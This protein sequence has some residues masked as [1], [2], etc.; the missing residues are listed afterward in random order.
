[1]S[2]NRLQEL[3]DFAEEFQNQLIEA[4]ELYEQKQ[5]NSKAIEPEH[6]KAEKIKSK[7]PL[8][9]SYDGKR[10][11][12]L[13]KIEKMNLNDEHWVPNCLFGKSFEHFKKLT[14]Q[15]YPTSWELVN[16]YILMFLIYLLI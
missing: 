4:K 15:H 12:R 6:L 1:M 13:K 7:F 8:Q 14:Y 9:K 11:L 2:E 3:N 5:K 10:K 16:K